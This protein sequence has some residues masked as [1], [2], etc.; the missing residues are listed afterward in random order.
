MITLIDYFRSG[1]SHRTRIALHLKAIPFE[2]KTVDLRAREHKQPAYLQINPQGLVPAVLIDG[3]ALNQSPA[4]LEW[5]EEAY[6]EPA[7]LPKD[8]M[9]RAQVRAIA[10]LVACDI[11][12]LG[13]MRVLVSLRTDHG[14]SEP[15]AMAFAKR[16]CV[17][18]LKALEA[19]IANGPS[20]A[21]PGPWC[22][23]AA[24]TLADC[25]VVPQLFAGV[26]R[27]AIDL[28]DYPL[29]ARVYAASQ[30]HPAFI[31]AHPD[32]Q[33]DALPNS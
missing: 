1:T 7:L 13:N 5:L 10:S 11:H 30:S 24:P 6:P 4:I 22:W 9:A 26:S 19:M 20:G 18:G 3:Q 12:P 2:H 25:C 27:Y 29:L 15:D 8:P 33:P 31:A 16:W 23:G 28:A 32:N 17:E 21:G 14:L